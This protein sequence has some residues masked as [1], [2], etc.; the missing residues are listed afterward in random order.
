MK[1]GKAQDGFLIDADLIDVGGLD[2]LLAAR[3]LDMV[4]KRLGQ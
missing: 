1:G 4:P 2:P 3:R